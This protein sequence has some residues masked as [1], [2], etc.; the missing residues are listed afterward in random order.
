MKTTTD[1]YLPILIT[2]NIAFRRDKVVQYQ[3]P[4]IGGRSNFAC[5]LSKAVGGKKM[6]FQPIIISFGFRQDIVF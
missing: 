6:F 3:M 1:F 2:A 4:T 5:I